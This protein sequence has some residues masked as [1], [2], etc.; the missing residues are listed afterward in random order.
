M[1]EKLC[2]RARH[3]YATF[4]SNTSMGSQTTHPLTL[5]DD[6]H[7][8]SAFGGTKGGVI[9]SPASSPPKGDTPSSESSLSAGSGDCSA[10][11]AQPPS[12]GPVPGPIQQQQSQYGMPYSTAQGVTGTG[13]QETRDF[14]PSLYV[15]RSQQQQSMLPSFEGGYSV[16][17]ER[18]QFSPPSQQE[19]A[20]QQSQNP[21]VLLTAEDTLDVDL[22]ALGLPPVSQQPM[23]YSLYPQLDQFRDIFM[24]ENENASVQSPQMPQ[25]DV[26]WKFVDDLGIQRI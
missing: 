17:S 26:W 7:D 13:A 11:S 21:M 15:P 1:L 6:I 18:T 22:A 8:L 16:S 2:T 9:K 23:Q 12:A 5:P 24:G 4:C 3:T 20:H 25:D 14:G 19:S 10:N